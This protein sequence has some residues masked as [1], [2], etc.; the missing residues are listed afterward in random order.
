MR[1]KLAQALA[2]GEKQLSRKY[3]ST[4]YAGL[5]LFSFAFFG[6]FLFTNTFLDWSKILNTT[7]VP[8]SDLN[9][10]VIIVFGFFALRLIFKLIVSVLL[11]HQQPAMR[12]VIDT[13]SKV[14]N[15]IIIF[16]LQTTKEVTLFRN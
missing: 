5:I 6:I 7:E 9:L 13:A 1:N 12:D 4:T 10:L 3:I 11:A 15:L 2:K 8:I 16:F 14:L